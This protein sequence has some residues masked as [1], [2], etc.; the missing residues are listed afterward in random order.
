MKTSFL[1]LFIFIS[2]DVISLSA[3]VVN[4]EQ[5]FY[6]KLTKSNN[7]T[8]SNDITLSKPVYLMPNQIINGNGHKLILNISDNQCQFSLASNNQ[9]LS[10]EI[11]S[12]SDNTNVMCAN[13]VSN[14]YLASTNITSS[15]TNSN[16]IVINNSN[17]VKLDSCNIIKNGTGNSIQANN[18]TTVV[19]NNF[20]ISHNS[21]DNGVIFSNTKSSIFINSI[22]VITNPTTLIQ[23]GLV[24]VGSNDLNVEDMRF[25]AYSNLV[26][27]IRVISGTNVMIQ[28]NTFFVNSQN[29]PNVAIG[30][31]FGDNNQMPFNINNISIN[32]N[33]FYNFTISNTNYL[34]ALNFSKT[35]NTSI[36]PQFNSGN[37]IGNSKLYGGAE[38]GA[39]IQGSV[40]FT[41]GGVFP[42]NN[43]YRKF[44]I[45]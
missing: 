7:I 14:A 3:L 34:A 24:I 15:G 1:K 13:N 6:D 38:N 20:Y 2:L 35:S 31:F 28:Y 32:N 16:A 41:D 37:V 42:N 18:S 36:N 21:P 25:F 27:V 12:T 43:G 29:L 30:I 44:F 39:T 11:V 17:V 5:D 8:L 26:D 4:S 33:D 19:I 10:M 22:F 23:A 45:H 40:S 9:I